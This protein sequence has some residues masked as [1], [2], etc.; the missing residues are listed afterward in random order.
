MGAHLVRPLVIHGV[1]PISAK[2]M[3]SGARPGER[4]RKYN[5]VRGSA[6]GAPGCALVHYAKGAN[7]PRG[8]GPPGGTALIR[9]GGHRLPN[10]D[11]QAAWGY[12]DQT[13]HSLVNMEGPAHAIP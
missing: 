7:L 2:G 4:F 9:T 8:P 5:A 13:K 1:H 3:W 6:E 10:A 11:I 12:H